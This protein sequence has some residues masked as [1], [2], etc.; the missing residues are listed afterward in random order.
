MT[1]PGLNQ[2]AHITALT[3][4]LSSTAW[5]VFERG[6]VPGF[7]SPAEPSR[8]L[9]LDL[10]RRYAERPRNSGQ[11]SRS[12]W[13]LGVVVVGA[14]RSQVRAGLRHVAAILDD[15]RL[16][17]SGGASTP[18]LH[19]STAEIRDDDHAFSAESAWTYVL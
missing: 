8:Y 6:E 11:A 4:L 16:S 10:E 3:A 17:V 7:G 14:Q 19:E 15:A 2:Q 9:L 5:P 1:A 13:R 12:G 18:L